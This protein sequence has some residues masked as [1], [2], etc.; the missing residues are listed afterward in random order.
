LHSNLNLQP[1]GARRVKAN[2]KNLSD[3]LEKSV[4]ARMRPKRVRQ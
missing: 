2:S 4:G 3:L 1:L